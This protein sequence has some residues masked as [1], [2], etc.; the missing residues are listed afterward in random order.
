MSRLNVIVVKN[1]LINNGWLSGYVLMTKIVAF[2]SESIFHARIVRDQ[3]DNYKTSKFRDF[4]LNFGDYWSDLA[5]SNA[6]DGI[7]ASVCRI[8]SH[9]L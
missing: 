2:A 3:F 1:D 8:T 6:V 9:I 5:F 7:D 4:C